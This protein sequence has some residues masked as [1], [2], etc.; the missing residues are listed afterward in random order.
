MVRDIRRTSDQ[1]NRIILKI[2]ILK[3]MNGIILQKSS[4]VLYCLK[5]I[6]RRRAIE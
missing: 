6:S 5:S 1:Y 3:K 2:Q 4:D